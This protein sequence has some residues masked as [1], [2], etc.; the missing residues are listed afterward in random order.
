M[1][2]RGKSLPLRDDRPSGFDAST[3]HGSEPRGILP[4][5][6]VELDTTIRLQTAG[7]RDAQ[8]PDSASHGERHFLMWYSYFKFSLILQPSCGSERGGGGGGGER[9][10]GTENE[11]EKGER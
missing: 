3:L 4:V 6:P 5:T 11:G 1:I 2:H 10:K 9:V 7:P 8:L